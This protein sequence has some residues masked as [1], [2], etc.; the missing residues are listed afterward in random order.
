LFHLKLLYN[1]AAAISAGANAVTK[2]DLRRGSDDKERI[3]DAI[4]STRIQTK[5]L[6]SRAQVKA[7]LGQYFADVPIEDL[8]GRSE[9]IMAR[10]ALNH[11]EFGSTRKKG[12]ALLR[13]YNPTE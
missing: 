3:L 7:Y 4:V 9:Q 2:Q 12:Q 6:S 5:A 10:I 1:A 8:I 13:I 11:L